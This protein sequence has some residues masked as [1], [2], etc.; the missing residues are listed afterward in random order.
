M[1]SFKNKYLFIAMAF[2]AVISICGTVSAAEPYTIGELITQDA[3]SDPDLGYSNADDVLCISNGGSAFLNDLT[4]ENSLQAIIDTTSELPNS[5]KI[6]TGKG[7]LIG[8][9]DPL[10]DLSFTFVAKKGTQIMAKQYKVISTDSSFTLSSGK[11]VEISSYISSSQW[12]ELEHVFGKNSFEIISIANAWASGAPID[13]LKIAG[14]SG[15]VSQGLISGYVMSK[16]FYDNYPL[17]SAE[18]SYHVITTPGGGDDN[19][20]EYL[21]ELSPLKWV[22]DSNRVTYFNYMAMDNGNPNQAAYMWWNRLTQNG[23]LALMS[24]SQLENVFETENGIRLI[25]GTISEIQFNSWLLDKLHNNPGSL[26]QVE[27][28]KQMNKDD[29]DYLWANGI[30]MDYLDNYMSNK[31]HT[32]LI[33]NIVTLVNYDQMYSI[34][35][36]AAL[37]A[38][39]ALDY[40]KGDS[41]LGVISSA[42]FVLLNGYSTQGALDGLSSIT[43]TTM[44]NLMNLKRAIWQPLWFT[45]IKKELNGQLNAVIVKYIN[46][47]LEISPVYDISGEALK[48]DKHAQAMSKVFSGGEADN[49]YFQQD[50]YI[51]SLANQWAIQTPYNYQISGVGGG[52]PGSGLSQGYLIAN[53][54]L[55]NYPLAPGQKYM[56]ISIPAH[57]KEQVIKDSLGVSAALGTYYTM[58][59]SNYALNPNLAGI[60]V[61]WDDF[62]Q[63]GTALLLNMDRSI[64]NT[65]QD[66]D[67]GPNNYYY[68]TMYWALWYIESAFP[69]QSRYAESLDAFSVLREI[70]ITQTE[71]SKMLSAGGDPVLFIQEYEIP[72]NDPTDPTTDPITDPIDSGDDYLINPDNQLIGNTE[73]DYSQIPS[74]VNA[75]TENISN[76]ELSTEAANTKTDPITSSASSGIPLYTLL[77]V[78]FITIIGVGLYFGKS[79]VIAAIKKSERLGK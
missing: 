35:K 71:L 64:I 63:T 14:S 44:D 16:S 23:V 62:S 38:Q 46:G 66:Q 42:G 4:T 29:F 33:E 51:I 27:M 65:M 31:A 56:T 26:I 13:L 74:I 20:P 53:Y 22:R 48:N 45:F 73:N 36:N 17:L 76:D 25:K 34:G 59:L 2:L 60:F 77:I 28:L 8:L 11:T 79:S 70:P 52:C 49:P 43:G 75:I 7:N 32:Y 6:T 1:K 78:I 39:S 24:S 30:D 54:V 47:N 9:L 21:L 72:I 58:G 3:I 15:G 37:M 12:N 41:N 10:G 67:F 19:V 50:Y 18:E 61:I 55:T 40:Q 69:G 5:Q 57:C 68:R